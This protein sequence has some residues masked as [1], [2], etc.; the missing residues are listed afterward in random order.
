MWRFKFNWETNQDQ[1]S[2]PLEVDLTWSCKWADAQEVL[3]MWQDEELQSKDTFAN[4][5]KNTG[6]FSLEKP[7]FSTGK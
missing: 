6:S 7:K 1:G 5:N 4:E 2:W 3:E